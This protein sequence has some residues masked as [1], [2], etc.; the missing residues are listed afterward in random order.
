TLTNTG[1]K[2]KR[3][4]VTSYVEW[5]LGATREKTRVDVQTSFDRAKSVIIAEN[6]LDPDIP[7]MTAFLSMTGSIVWYTTSRREVSGR[8]VALSAAIA[9]AENR[10]AQEEETI[11]DSC[12]VLGGLV[13]LAPGETKSIAIALGAANGREEATQ[14]ASR[15]QDPG[16]AN[17]AIDTAVA[18]WNSRLSS[19]TVRTPE[20]ALDLMLNKWA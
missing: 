1:D 18:Q 20:P 13:E 3:I 11:P 4:T 19:I 12:G 8:N 2:R 7:S 14:L 17:A 16:S 15:Y 10:W 5:V 6:P 9:L